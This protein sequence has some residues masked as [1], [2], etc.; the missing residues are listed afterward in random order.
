MNVYWMDEQI[1]DP[2]GE[3]S[4]ISATVEDYQWMARALQLARNGIYTTHP[5]PRVGC[6]IVNNG[7][8]VGEG[9]HHQAGE[10]HAEI[11]ALEQAGEKARNA[12]MYVTLEPCCHH[13]RTPPCVESIIQAGVTK[14]VIASRDPNPLVDHAGIEALQQSGIHVTTNVC[15]NL[16]VQMNCGFFSRMRR[17]RPW[18]TLKIAISLDGKTA[19]ADGDSKWI[20]SSAAREDVHR[21]RAA[22]SAIMTGIGTV[23]RDDPSMTARA[24]GV[25]IQ[26]L[27][28]ILDSNLSTPVYAK[29]LKQPGKTVIITT[30]RNQD[31]ELMPEFDS[32]VEVLVMP[33]K[34]NRIDLEAVLSELGK[35]EVNDLLLE[36]GAE[37]S[38]SMLRLNLV[39]ELVVYM[40]PDLLGSNTRGMFEI[41]Q[42]QSL[43]DKLR[44]EFGEIRKIGRDLRLTLRPVRKEA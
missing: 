25:E 44:F 3:S 32:S 39:D 27:R 24:P 34:D 41:H 18:V 19:M 1:A 31:P 12:V 9:W 15:R 26:P 43:D 8:V 23:L 20:T 40:A 36:A 35:L 28:V 10:K 21:L 17:Q 4:E 14:V 38:G 2:A 22:S 5:N 30:G 16:A 11:I 42:L 6:V 37:L 29:I 13:G 33:E 7:E